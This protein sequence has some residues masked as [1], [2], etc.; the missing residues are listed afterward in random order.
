MG[1]TMINDKSELLRNDYL[2]NAMTRMSK[3]KKQTTNNQWISSTHARFD[4]INH[5]SQKRSKFLTYC[6]L[7]IIDYC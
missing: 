4:K 2:Q 1:I 7:L 3:N 5:K 6:V